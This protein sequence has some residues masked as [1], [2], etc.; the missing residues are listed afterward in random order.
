M[1]DQ[2]RLFDRNA[3]AI[4]RTELLATKYILGYKKPRIASSGKKLNNFK[5][6]GK[7]I[8][9]RVIGSKPKEQTQVLVLFP[10]VIGNGLDNV[11]HK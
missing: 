3:L 9:L 2:E 5:K 8:S 1:D 10:Q 11:A 7:E 6:L 4:L